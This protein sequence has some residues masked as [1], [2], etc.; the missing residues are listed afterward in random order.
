M[1]SVIN[2]LS[3]EFR[4]AL[5]LLLKIESIQKVLSKILKTANKKNPVSYLLSFF[6]FL[7]ANWIG[8]KVSTNN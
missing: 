4:Y 1:L 3:K 8:N 6:I 7:V 2:C 5:I